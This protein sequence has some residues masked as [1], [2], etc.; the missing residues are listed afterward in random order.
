MSIWEGY[1]TKK[2]RG[3]PI[4]KKY[5]NVSYKLNTTHDVGY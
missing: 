3:F 5:I 1:N 4:I 2:L